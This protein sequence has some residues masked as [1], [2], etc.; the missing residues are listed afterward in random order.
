MVNRFS[1]TELKILVYNK[2]KLKGM[3]YA[4]A[5]KEISTELETLKKNK[6]QKK[7]ENWINSS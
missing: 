7:D 6:E 2:M 3:S 4:E 1:K 5:Y